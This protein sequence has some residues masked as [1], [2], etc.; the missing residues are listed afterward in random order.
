MS[1]KVCELIK[2]HTFKYRNKE[3]RPSGL[4]GLLYIKFFLRTMPDI[5][6]VSLT[7]EKSK[8]EVNNG[9]G[10]IQKIPTQNHQKYNW[11]GGGI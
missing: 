2:Q 6:K 10:R 5:M 7:Q 11:G 1:F 4:C 8:E 3:G 9:N